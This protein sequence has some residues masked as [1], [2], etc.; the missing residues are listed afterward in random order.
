MTLSI[1]E[2]L[3]NISKLSTAEEK[4]NA[5]R[6]NASPALYTIIKGALDP[7]VKW[8][9]PEGKPPYKPNDLVDQQGVFYNEYKKLYLFIEGGNPGLN[10]VRREYLFIQLLEN[11][12]PKD[13][14]LLV[15]VKDK[16]FPYNI[17]R[18][19]IEAAF[20]GLL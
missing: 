18:D 7:A 10:Q 13:A 15:Y 1:S 17:T 3:A 8:L 6:S 20:P 16:L 4:I 19:H 14:E 11:L 2:I 5:L 9:L 12:D